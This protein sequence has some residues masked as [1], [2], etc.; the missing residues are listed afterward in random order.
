MTRLHNISL[1]QLKIFRAIVD[2]GNLSR[3][4]HE[5][6]LT[7][8]AISTALKSLESHIG[9][10]TIR[11]DKNGKI[12]ILP[13]GKELYRLCLNIESAL[14][15][16]SKRIQSLQQ[17]Y[18]GHI[19]IGIVTTSKY[20]APRIINSIGKNF[21]DIE[22]DLFIGNRS[23]IIEALEANSVQMAIMGRPPRKPA[24]FHTAIG[25]H[26][27]IIVAAPEYDWD[28]TW[29]GLATRDF[30]VREES[31][32]T[33]ILFERIIATSPIT[34][35]NR[36]IFY[37]NES[38]KQAVMAD[39]GIAFLSASTCQFELEAGRLKTIDLPELPVYREWYLVWKAG[40]PLDPVAKIVHD[41]IVTNK[42]ELLP[43]PKLTF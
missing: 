29:Q 36:K 19:R 11:R 20:F 15:Q 32:G 18:L 43:M 2:M 8:P 30:I 26:P 24:V 40:E 6:G 4:S 9:T 23:E 10:A 3:A 38:I 37:S 25:K 34:H 41:F 7:A 17:G 35:L 1:R 5:I 21:S 39:L 13:A 12:D 33:R 42:E 14:E 27:H 16:T 28:K 31:S 22:I